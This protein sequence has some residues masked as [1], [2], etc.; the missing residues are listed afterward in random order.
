MNILLWHVHGSWTTSFVQGK[1]RYLIPVNDARDADLDACLALA[2]RVPEAEGDAAVRHLDGRLAEAPDGRRR[3]RPVLD[4]AAVDVVVI[5]SST[6]VHEEH[7]LAA[8]HDALAR[9]AAPLPRARQPNDAQRRAALASDV[10][11][12]PMDVLRTAERKVD[13]A[14]RYG[15][16]REFVD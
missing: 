6:D 7:V 3:Q 12:L 5:G 10:G 9:F 2:E 13:H 16:V 14:R 15:R 11:G 4:D 1:H 8:V